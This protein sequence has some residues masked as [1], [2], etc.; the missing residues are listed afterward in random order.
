MSR[1]G[2]LLPDAVQGS[3]TSH[4][5]A[6]LELVPAP[7]RGQTKL[8]ELGAGHCEIARILRSRGWEV[9]TADI[10]ESCVAEALALGFPATRLDL[11]EALPYPDGAFHFV[12]MLEVIEHVVRAELALGEAARV[13]S[14]GGRLLLSTPNHAFYKSRVRMLKGRPLGMEGEHFRFFVKTQLESLFEKNGFRIIGRNSSGHLPLMDGRW[15]RRLLGRKRVLFRIPEWLEPLCAINFVW[16]AE[17][18]P[19]PPKG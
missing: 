1:R 11:N 6:A 18:V 19:L 3:Y 2:A 15:L 4:Y 8:L 10:Q 16:L 7:S 14:P 17:R 13:L 12:V 5:A 9:H